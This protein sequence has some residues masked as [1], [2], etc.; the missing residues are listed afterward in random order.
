MASK[1]E[2]KNELKNA[3]DSIQ[4]KDYKAAL[5]HCKVRDMIE[6]LL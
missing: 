6:L 2:V 3:R 1:S 5:K 4:S